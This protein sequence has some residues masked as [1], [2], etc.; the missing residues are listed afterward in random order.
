MKKF[1]DQFFSRLW[2]YTIIL[3]PYFQPQSLYE[4]KTSTILYSMEV[5]DQHFSPKSNHKQISAFSF[6]LV[7]YS[8]TQ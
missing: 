2:N 6:E 8:K 3:L 1:I 4:K 5:Y 7:F